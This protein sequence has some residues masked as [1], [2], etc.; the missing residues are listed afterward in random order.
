MKNRFWQLLLLILTLSSCSD[1]A[2]LKKAIVQKAY[3]IPHLLNDSTI[4]LFYE[5]E[6]IPRGAELWYHTLNGEQDFL[7]VYFRDDD[8]TGLRVVQPRNFLRM[9]PF[10]GDTTKLDYLFFRKSLDNK[11]RVTAEDTARVQHVLF[12]HVETQKVFLSSNPFK[13]LS[14]LSALKDSLGVIGITQNHDL[15]N[16]IEFYLSPQ[17]ILT[18]LPDSLR[19]DPKFKAIWLSDFAKGKSINKNWNLR[20]LPKPVDIR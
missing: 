9:F 1:E 11:L 2:A 19:I 18:Y 12:N 13:K 6:Y 4:R 16:F 5:W 20:L 14:E 7:C 3:K 10:N 15:G 17:A 8:T